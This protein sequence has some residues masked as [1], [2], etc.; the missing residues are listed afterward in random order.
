[1]SQYTRKAYYVKKFAGKVTRILA[2]TS[3]AWKQLF[4]PFPR[5]CEA[6]ILGLG[7]RIRGDGQNPEQ[8]GYFGYRRDAGGARG[9]YA[10]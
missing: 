6:A 2:G 7:E 8:S 3:V 10:K 5:Y 9:Y 4:N 1:M